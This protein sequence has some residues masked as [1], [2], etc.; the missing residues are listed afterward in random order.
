[1]YGLELPHLQLWIV[2]GFSGLLIWAALSDLGTFT[3]P[4]RVTLSILLLYPAYW[5]A[6]DQ[7]FDLLPALLV[8]A[9]VFAAGALLF[10]AHF[11]GGG[12]VK[13]LA[14]V[15]LW[16][17][18]DLVLPFLLLTALVGGVLGLMLLTPLGNRLPQPAGPA[19]MPKRRSRR[20]MPYGIAISVAGLFVATQLPGL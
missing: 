20:P 4:N 2:W 13:L 8:A 19:A 14:V 6:L 3:I 17:G 11:M 5:F 18:P 12:D 10:A 9:I 16:A 1:M 15:A 7:S